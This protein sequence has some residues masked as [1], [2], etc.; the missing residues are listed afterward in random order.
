MIILLVGLP[1]HGKTSWLQRKIEEIY[2]E[3]RHEL[4]RASCRVIDRQNV[5]REIKLE[6]PQ[7][8]M[9]PI[10][11]TRDMG[12]KFRVK[13]DEYYEPYVLNVYHISPTNSDVPPQYFLPYGQ[14]FIPE[15]QK[16]FNSRQHQTLDAGVYRFFET[17][18][19]NHL[20]IYMDCHVGGFIDVRIRALVEKVI[21]VTHQTNIYDGLG[22]ITHTTWH[23]REF[24]CLQD[25]DEYFR[26]HDVQKYK[27][28]TYEYEG[29]IRK[30]YNGHGCQEELMPPEGQQYSMLKPLSNTEIRELTPEKAIYYSVTE[31]EGYRG[32]KTTQN[33]NKG[34]KNVTASKNN[35]ERASSTE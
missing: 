1:R 30:H 5:G 9:P 18:G 24:D 22:G 11:A 8:D 2:N 20:D 13:R 7:K 21:E 17:H 14:L 12:S 34:N 31:P 32:K 35:V 6:Y 15:A 28:T 29:D 25:Y 26:N 19:H 4:W 33:A 3:H 23:C 16:Y 10:Y 27:E